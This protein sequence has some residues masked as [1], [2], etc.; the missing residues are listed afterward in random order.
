VLRIALHRVLFTPVA[1][2][3]VLLGRRSV[4]PPKLTEKGDGSLLLKR[5]PS[6]F[7]RRVEVSGGCN[8]EVLRW[9]TI[10]AVGAFVEGP[11]LDRLIRAY[12][13]RGWPHEVVPV[14]AAD[15]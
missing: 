6:P 7:P 5:L 12:R 4:G 15:K 10:K 1:I 9:I 11:L 13:A 14:P 2:C 8:G 3:L